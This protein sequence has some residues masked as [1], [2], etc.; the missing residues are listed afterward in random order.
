MTRI[1]T[2]AREY[3]SGGA[4]IGSL[5]ASRLGWSLVDHAFIDHV[6]QA[7]KVEPKL[8][9]RWDECVDSWFDRMVRALWRG[10]Y[11]GSSSATTEEGLLDA[12]AM[13]RL[14]AR[15]IEEAAGIGNCIIVGRGAQCILRH[16][17]DVFHVFVYAP[18]RQKIER[19]RQR[20]GAKV[21]AEEVI[22]ERD[23]QRI[24]YIHRHFEH[25]WCDR[26]LYHLLVNSSIG[27]EN[28]VRTVIAAAGLGEP[29]A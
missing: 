3:G 2:I 24:A 26:R 13:A 19:V 5:L 14:A 29:A 11:E 12:D 20:L 4:T 21:N 1:I 28:A 27:E 23:Q 9:E 8:V 7:M 18:W 6:A 16:R 25:D 10:G 15:T 22:R 17:Q